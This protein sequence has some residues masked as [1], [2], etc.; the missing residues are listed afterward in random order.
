MIDSIS[1]M[2]GEIAAWL[3]RQTDTFSDVTFL[4]E[5]P[6]IPKATPLRQTIAAI[7]L[8]HVRISDFFTENSHGEQVP[9]EYCRLAS[10]RIRISVYVPYSAG[11]TACHTAFTKIVDCLN[12]K[13][14]F[15]ISESGCESIEADRDTDAFVLKSWIDIQAQFCPAE[16]TAVQY[17]AFMPKTLFCR[18]H[19]DNAD[20]HVT[21][22]EKQRWG[23]PMEVGYYFGTNAASRTIN[24]GYH[25]RL[26]LVFPSVYPPIYNS[27]SDTS[28]L[29]CLCGMA[30]RSLSSCGIE[31]TENGFRLTQ[32]ADT[33]VG[34][35]LTKL[36]WDSADYLYVALR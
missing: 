32:S 17:A 4:T 33:G 36:N 2:P 10:V 18:S 28:R 20:I 25:P 6:A 14:D 3:S 11:G 34:N 8:D 26:V 12:F 15:N 16:S 24:L 27:S 29:I 9:D 31:L 5:F 7:G 35:T 30:G 23:S 1:A 22:E 21:P 13:S 19:M